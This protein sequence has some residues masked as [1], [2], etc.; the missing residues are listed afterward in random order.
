LET[1]FAGGGATLVDVEVT[2]VVGW[3]GAVVEVVG[4][5]GGTYDGG[6]L[7]V[8]LVLVLVPTWSY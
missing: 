1:V 7:A 6:D 3:G 5:G 4:T 8:V 2:N